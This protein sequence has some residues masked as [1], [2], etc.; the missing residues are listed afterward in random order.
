MSDFIVIMQC[1]AAK[2]NAKYLKDGGRDVHFVANPNCGT[3]KFYKRPDDKSLS[4]KTYR[5]IVD[6]QSNENLSE[7]YSIYTP[8]NPYK[9]IYKEL[10][11]K[12]GKRLYILSAGWGIVRA[13]FKLPSYDITFNAGAGK[14]KHRNHSDAGYKD[15]NH[16]ALDFPANPPPVICI[17]SHGYQEQY[18]KLMG[19]SPDKDMPTFAWDNNYTRYYETARRVIK[20]DVL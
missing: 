5:E 14:L 3:E 8:N 7:A 2:D 17:G 13:E 1:C 18:K 9:D 10:F 15:Y 6:L 16:L 20:G 19:R 11:E 4:G 12:F